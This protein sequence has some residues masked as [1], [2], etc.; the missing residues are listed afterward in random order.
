[1]SRMN[2]RGNGPPG[3]PRRAPPGADS[4]VSQVAFGR[5]RRKLKRL[6]S[7]PLPAPSSVMRKSRERRVPLPA[8]KV[9]AARG[10]GGV[11]VERHYTPCPANY[12]GGVGFSANIVDL[13]QQSAYPSSPSLLTARCDAISLETDPHPRGHAGG[14]CS[15]RHTGVCGFNNLEHHWGPTRY[16]DCLAVRGDNPVAR[17][18][19]PGQLP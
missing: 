19:V 14:L 17:A 8:W 7:R 15:D 10:E 12:G 18:Q 11:A 13:E 2:S 6:L 3:P 9:R 1:L 16:G 4:S 5:V